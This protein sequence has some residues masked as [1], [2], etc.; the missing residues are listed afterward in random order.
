MTNDALICSALGSLN[1]PIAEL[2]YK[3]NEDSFITYSLVSQRSPQGDNDDTELISEY[4]INAFTRADNPNPLRRNIRKKLKAAGICVKTSQVLYDNS[5][6]EF[7]H[8]VFDV[9]FVNDDTS[10]ETNNN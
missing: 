10:I 9:E 8:I 3:G 7:F 5:Q 2:V 6:Q 1:L 4:Y